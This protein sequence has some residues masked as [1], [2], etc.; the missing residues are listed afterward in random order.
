[1]VDVCNV[2]PLARNQTVRSI[3]EADIPLTPSSGHCELADL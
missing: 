1:M 2:P 3:Q